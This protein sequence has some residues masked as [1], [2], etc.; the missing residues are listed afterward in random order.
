MTL[1]SPKSKAVEYETENSIPSF[2]VDANGFILFDQEDLGGA[3]IL[4]VTPK[5]MTEGITHLDSL[6]GEKYSASS[7]DKN[8]SGMEF[9]DARDL[10]YAPWVYFLN[11]LL[12]QHPDEE[13]I[14]IQIL[15]KYCLMSDWDEQVRTSLDYQRILVDKEIE[16]NR[17]KFRGCKPTRKQALVEARRLDYRNELTSIA[18]KPHVG[19]GIAAH[20]IKYYL[21]VSYT[22]SAEGWWM[23]GR[24]SDYYRTDSN[25]SVFSLFDEDKAVDRIVDF[26]MKHRRSNA[27]D[28]DN[29]ADDYFRVHTDAVSQVLHSRVLRVEKIVEKW[30]N[31]HILQKMPFTLR[32]LHMRESAALIAMFPRIVSSYWDKIWDLKENMNEILYGLEADIAIA[33][34]DTEFMHRYRDS[35]INTNQADTTLTSEALEAFIDRYR[36]STAVEENQQERRQWE[37]EMGYREAASNETVVGSFTGMDSGNLR[38]AEANME[39]FLAQY[40]NRALPYDYL[41][42]RNRMREVQQQSTQRGSNGVPNMGNGMGTTANTGIGSTYDD[43]DGIEDKP[44]GDSSD[45]ANNGGTRHKRNLGIKKR[46]RE[47]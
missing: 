32:R 11:N 21:V 19:I 6:T 7:K 33:K 35:I 28:G 22:P 46:A 17:R 24:D 39:D 43:F 42:Y 38:G 30:N 47:K 31:T 27:R 2:H 10:I 34:G 45:S 37:I 18:G 4:E 15:A 5:V 41:E 44:L 29:T 9:G 3:A 14:H 36:T 25:L 16:A 8:Q 23:D 26:L 20:T 1:F 13:P 12:P 40:R